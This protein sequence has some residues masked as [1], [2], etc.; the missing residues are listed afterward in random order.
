MALN[1]N[2]FYILLV[3]VAAAVIFAVFYFDL[4]DLT[5]SKERALAT[6]INYEDTR[7]ASDQLLKYL[8]DPDAEIRARAALALGRI[9]DP[10]TTPNILR[11][12]EDS[13]DDVRAAAAFAVGLTGDSRFAAE[14][15]DIGETQPAPVLALVIQS[16]GRLADTTVPIVADQIATMLNH[17]DHRVRE[18]A[19]MA[20]WRCR[21]TAYTENLKQMAMF[22]PV[23]AVQIA[24]LYSLV[25]LR[26]SD[27]VD[28]YAEWLPDSDPFAR[29]QAIRGL[30]LTP[31]DSRTS[32]VAAGLN[33]RNNHVVIE[34]INALAKINTAKAVRY[35]LARLAE[36]TDEKVR[37]LLI[38]TLGQMGAVEAE[39]IIL[40]GLNDSTSVNILGV[41]VVAL[42]KLEYDYIEAL[43]DS[44]LDKNNPWLE[45]KIIEALGEI[46]GESIKPRLSDLFNDSSAMVRG[47]AFE[48]L[49]KYD[50]LNA[51]YYIK[52]ALKDSDDVMNVRAIEYIGQQKMT[53]MIREMSQ[54][55]NFR[56]TIHPDV[57]RSIA[58]AAGEFLGTS[59]DSLAE[60]LLN[61]CLLDAD[62]IVSKTAAGIYKDK[63]EQDKTAYISKPAESASIGQIKDFLNKYN[64][65]PFAIIKTNRG[66]IK[67]E[68][69][70]DIAPLTVKS[71][72]NLAQSGFYDG[73]IF[74]RVVPG[75]VAQGGD[76]RGDGY[77]GPDFTLRTEASNITFARGAVG[78]ASSGKDTEGSQ[79]FI[80][81]MPVPHL[82]GKYT[83]FG[84]VVS[85]MEIADALV[86]G[87]RIENIRIMTGKEK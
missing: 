42:A 60:S 27:A 30:G 62:Y 11:L 77:G 54:L 61:E 24:A 59:E 49:V 22:D 43:V 50:P 15:M 83:L 66:E 32:L 14:L 84:T 69:F 5:Y 40:K 57:K 34:A 10:N 64:D 48:A 71:F 47:A 78:M 65:D 63:L 1:K 12:L 81:V 9:S 58:E 38:E 20:M 7:R 87:D 36:E 23:R 76:P 56:E 39:E 31:D 45:T 82:D 85:G 80:T 75:F 28:T 4:F 68:L 3:L 52:T 17:L 70:K 18:Q 2:G 72:I 37:G 41:S 46:G 29:A 13:V 44:L 79:F 8:E 86:R 73:L 74:H 21:G 26:V 16:A 6:I 67:I 19:A 53:D 25:G 55:M 35:L 51:K 33:D